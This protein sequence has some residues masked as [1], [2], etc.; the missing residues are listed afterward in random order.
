MEY[1]G[2]SRKRRPT[3]DLQ[4][5]SSGQTHRPVTLNRFMV[6]PMKA[7]IF[8]IKTMRQRGCININIHVHV[9]VDLLNTSASDVAII[10]NS[11]M[12]FK[13]YR[14]VISNKFYPQFRRSLSGKKE[15]IW[16]MRVDLSD[17]ILKG[18]L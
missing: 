8:P 10:L 7:S 14:S 17:I 9:G 1:H 12:R 6:G 5:V 3:P 13:K 18:F 16:Y 15:K 4:I 11:T 2:P